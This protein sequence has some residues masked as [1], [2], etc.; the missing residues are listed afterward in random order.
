MVER[1]KRFYRQE[2]VGAVGEVV[3][4]GVLLSEVVKLTRPKWRDEAQ[5]TGR[6]IEFD[7][8]AEDLVVVGGSPPELGELFTNLVFNAVDAMPSGGRIALSLRSTGEFAEVEL[9][10][11]GTGIDVAQTT[12]PTGGRG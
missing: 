12:R 1:L 10:D 4:L 11:T 6:S 9:A 7:L 5:R 2:P 3:D 8:Q